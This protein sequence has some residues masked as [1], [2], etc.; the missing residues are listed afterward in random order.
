MSIINYVTEKS[1]NLDVILISFNQ[2]NEM[3]SVILGNDN[4][5]VINDLSA[6]FPNDQLILN[7]NTDKSEI[8]EFLNNPK[9]AHYFNL[10][11]EGTEFQKKVW[12]ELRNIEVGET[13]SYSELAK[14]I[15]NS[16]AVRAVA[17]A[18]A[19]NKIAILIPCHRV[20]NLS[21]KKVSY[22]WGAERKL[23]L[24]DLEKSLI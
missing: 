8:F 24:L 21:G 9:K 3:T 14:R 18:C 15:G 13:I 6:M 11:L 4:E 2:N 10:N 23:K 19:T 7:E 12:D 5:S 16:K 17:S 20:V 1:K 22:R